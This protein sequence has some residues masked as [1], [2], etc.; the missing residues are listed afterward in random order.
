MAS[1][2][3][4]ESRA[5]IERGP[6]IAPRHR[7]FGQL[8][9]ILGAMAAEHSFYKENSTGVSGDVQSATARAAWMVGLCGM[10]PEPIDLNGRLFDSEQERREEEERVMARF[11]RIGNQIMNRARGAKEQGDAI[12]AILGDQTKRAA[13]AQIL[14]QAYITAVCLIR[15]N[16]DKVLQIAETLIDRREL[17]GDEVVEVLDG[18]ALEAPRIDVTDETIWPRL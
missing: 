5:I 13:A 14:G 16:R 4:A 10:G 6:H 12:A 18:V 7:Q 9:W 3:N 11:E 17:H 2:G 8:V 15:H 1:P